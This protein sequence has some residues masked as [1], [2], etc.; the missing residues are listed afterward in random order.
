MRE[1][2]LVREPT[3]IPIFQMEII[4]EG[5]EEFYKWLGTY[6]PECLPEPAEGEEGSWEDLFPPR[7]SGDDW[8]GG[9]ETDGQ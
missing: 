6:R 2:T 7:W 5:M 4:P 1:V 3:I 9:A 8:G